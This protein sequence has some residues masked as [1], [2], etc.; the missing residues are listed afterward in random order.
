MTKNLLTLN[1]LTPREL[2]SLLKRALEMKKKRSSV[3]P[4]LKGKI[5]GLIFEKS[6]TR[7]RVSFEAAMVRLGGSSI[8]LDKQA[9]QLGRGETYA[10]TARVL[11]RYL[12][13]LVLR[14]YA[15]SD[16]E[17]LAAH[18]PIPVINGLTDEFHPCQ[19][20]ADLLTLLE[21]KKD[22]K[23]IKVAYVGDGNNM[24]NTWIQAAM[25]LGFDLR[26]GCPQGYGPD[27]TLMAE[28]KQFKNILITDD[29]IEAVA[30]CDAINTDTWFSMGQEVSDEKRNVFKKFQVNQKLVSHAHPK[31]IVLHCLPAHRGEEITD[32]VMDGPQSVIFDEA[33][34]RL[35]VQMALL[36]KLLK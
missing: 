12:N 31:A 25:I 29:P 5:L 17:E 33:E 2:T 9:S 15:Q 22:L 7:T 10:D 24:A 36:E 8:Y 1:D 35:H 4:V 11:S 23:K 16:L 32:E 27:K 30:G 13:G 6:S 21:F 18:A 34:N 20:M 3:K 28:S 14:A 26:L 19:V